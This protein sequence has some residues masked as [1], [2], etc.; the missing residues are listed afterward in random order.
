M[1][2]IKLLVLPLCAVMAVP[3]AACGSSGEVKNSAPEIEGVSDIQCLTFSTV[4]LLYGV[5]ALDKEDGDITPEMKVSVS[6]D[7]ELTDGIATFTQ[8]GSYSVSY[9]VADGEGE[10]AKASRVV[11]VVEREVYKSFSQPDLFSLTAS[12][13]AKITQGGMVNGK[14]VIRGNGGILAEDLLLSRKYDL[15][16]GQH[17]TF[18]YRLESN[19]A[20]RIKATAD[21]KNIGEFM[22]AEGENTLTFAHKAEKTASDISLCL[23]R[24][25]DGIEIKL[26]SVT[27]LRPQNEG[28]EIVLTGD[29]F[30]FKD[31]VIA[32][33][34]NG[35][36]GKAYATEDNKACLEITKPNGNIWEG[37]AFINTG[38]TMRNGQKYVISYTA[39]AEKENDF[40]VVIQRGQWNEKHLKTNYSPKGKVTETV[41]INGETAG[42][43][44]LYIQ[45]GNAENKITVS[46]LS[47]TEVLGANE[48]IDI[49]LTDFT[50]IHPGDKDGEGNELYKSTLTTDCGKFV[51]EIEN[52]A[53]KD[54]K[55]VVS[56]QQFFLAGSANNCVITFKAKATAPVTM[57]FAGP[58]AGG[59][60]PSLAWER[61][62]LSEE[63]QLY[64][65]FCGGDSFDRYHKLVWQFGGES[66]MKYHNVKIEISDVRV[67]LRYVP[68]DG[69]GNN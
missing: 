8:P 59:W 62:T 21:G 41:E 60:D 68:I 52:F 18:I 17:Y 7:V 2:K 9:T 47:V 32:R 58:V 53:D 6:P 3:L 15:L 46:D 5:A 48:I 31:R 38:V 45:S 43:L 36:E 20:G 30:E 57:V 16:S 49:P 40:E 56:S 28:Q 55:Q 42:E 44:W 1:K 63:E 27:C 12:G 29:G 26:N 22:L 39:E 66:N 33:I 24:L 61:I 50:E 14:Y 67:N 64:T 13:Q 54:D 11:E 34:E 37:G 23:G 19:V 10:E 51:Y 4:D 35:N 65:V 25:G 69:D